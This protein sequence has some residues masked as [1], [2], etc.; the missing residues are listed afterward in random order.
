MKTERKILEKR[1]P[2][3]NVERKKKLWWDHKSFPPLCERYGMR[4][5]EE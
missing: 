1:L 3:E 5:S 2:T 4:R